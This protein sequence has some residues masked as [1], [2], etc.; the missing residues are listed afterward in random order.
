MVFGGISKY[1]KTNLIVITKGTVDSLT[2]IDD[3]ID[4]SGLIPE[5]NEVYG[6]KKW[7]LM[8]DGAS[9][10]TAHVTLDY[11]HMLIF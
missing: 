1:H 8:Q 2:Y 6:A 10:H 7:I 11:K 3:L 5:M 4:G 9:A